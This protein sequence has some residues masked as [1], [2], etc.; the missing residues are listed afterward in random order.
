MKKYLYLLIIMCYL[1][2]LCVSIA[3]AAIAPISTKE[4]FEKKVEVKTTVAGYDKIERYY[5]NEH[6][7]K[8]I[9]TSEGISSTDKDRRKVW[10]DKSTRWECREYIGDVLYRYVI[11]YKRGINRSGNMTGKRLSDIFGP[12]YV[13]DKGWEFGERKIFA[14]IIGENHFL[15][16]LV[17][18]AASGVILQEVILSD[19]SNDIYGVNF[20]KDACDGKKILVIPIFN[21]RGKEGGGPLF[22]VDI[23][24]GQIECLSTPNVKKLYVSPSKTYLIFCETDYDKGE[25]ITLYDLEKRKVVFSRFFGGSTIKEIKWSYKEMYAMIVIASSDDRVRLL[26]VNTLKGNA[27]EFCD[28]AISVSPS[29]SGSKAIYTKVNPDFV[30]L[31]PKSLDREKKVLFM[32]GR[33]GVLKEK[34]PDEM[35]DFSMLIFS[36]LNKKF[37]Q[38]VDSACYPDL[39]NAKW[40]EKESSVIFFDIDSLYRIVWGRKGKSKQRITGPLEQ[41][42]ALAGDAIHQ[43]GS[44]SFFVLQDKVL[45]YLRGSEHRNE[46]INNVLAYKLSDMNRNL[47]YLTEKEKSLNLYLYNLRNKEQIPLLLGREKIEDF[48]FK[49]STIQILEV[50]VSTN[51]VTYDEPIVI[52]FNENGEILPLY[53][54]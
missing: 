15:Q 28:G 22:L 14:R 2:I 12:K 42:I 30:G 26:R 52:K 11:I 27:M 5:F 20:L 16:I 51:N 35:K 43:L 1:P 4:D 29:P 6:L 32:E 21:K 19:P 24:T 37:E 17:I 48:N 46:M 49:S 10:E 8:E 40:A 39:F 31:R 45:Y 36:D 33:N 41:S 23:A 9:I 53:S 44:N 47:A 25:G 3:R 34:T 13:F 50:V 7:L 54:Y 38:V 18:S